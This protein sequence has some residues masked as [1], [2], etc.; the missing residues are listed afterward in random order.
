M[1]LSSESLPHNGYVLLDQL[2][3]KELIPFVRTYLKKRTPSSIFFNVFNIIIVAIIVFC[4][5]IY[6]GNEQFSIGRGLMYFC[7][8]IGLAFLLIPLHE[9]IHVLAYKSQGALHTS[10]DAHLKKFYFLAIADQFVAN[11][12]EFRIVALVPFVEISTLLIVGCFFTNPY[13]TL[14]LLGTL[15]THTACCSGDFG[16]LSYFDFHH[17]KEIVTYDDKE[18][19]MSYFFWKEK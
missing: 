5:L 4:F 9:Y 11:K 17:D 13:Y 19:K 1:T 18:K 2:D 16:L 10:Y 8:G 3:H 14:L 12:K 15:L 7:N 6:H